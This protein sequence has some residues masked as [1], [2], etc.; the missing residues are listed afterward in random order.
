MR[1][2]NHLPALA[3]ALPLLAAFATPLFA[4]VSAKARTVG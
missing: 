4:A 2:M 1:L 3:L